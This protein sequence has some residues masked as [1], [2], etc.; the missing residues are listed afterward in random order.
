LTGLLLIAATHNAPMNANGCLPHT[1][2]Q[3]M[4]VETIIYVGIDIH[5]KQ[6]QST[7]MVESGKVLEQVPFKNSGDGLTYLIHRIKPYGEAKAVLESTGNFWLK[8]YE[9]LEKADIHVSLSNPLKTRAI[10]EARIKTDKI[11]AKLLAHLLRAN[12]VAESYV[13]NKET[14]DR[15]ALLRHRSSVV[16]TRTEIKNRVHNQLDKYDLQPEYS[17]LFGNKGIEWLRTLQLPE[18]EKT[19]L[20]SNLDLLEALNSQIE[21]I[22]LEI[23][24]NAVDKDDVKLLMTLPGIDYYAAMVIANE[25]GDVTRFPEANKL[26][27]WAGLAPSTRQS[28][29]RVKHGAITKQGNKTLRWVLIQATHNACRNDER[30]GNFYQRI[31]RRRG[32]NKATVA[33]AREML[34][35]I[36]HMLTRKEPYRGV[37]EE[38][39]HSKLK[40][41]ERLGNSGL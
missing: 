24:S 23:A 36:Y 9:A 22:N 19:I 6:C 41:L 15:R 4:E 32:G 17:D 40:R 20:Q 16:K 10:A 30:L 2:Q 29:N 14:R 12:L 37:D 26:V 31:A 35:I 25:I 34:V 7:L 8:S 27:S 3:E 21:K 18:I 38:L 1:S 5:K 33:V 28:R 11:D 39:Y 13:P